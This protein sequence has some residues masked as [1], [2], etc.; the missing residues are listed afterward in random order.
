[1]TVA[2]VELWT[3]VRRLRTAFAGGA[4]MLAAGRAQAADRLPD[5]AELDRLTARL[6]AAV[7]AAPPLADPADALE[8]LAGDV[9]AGRYDRAAATRALTAIQQAT[10]PAL[11]G[12]LRPDGGLTAGQAASAAAEL[13]PGGRPVLTAH[14]LARAST[15][16]A[17][18]SPAEA[19]RLHIL[20]DSSSPTLAAYLL[21]ALAAGH[22][23]PRVDQLAADV[24][25]YAADSDWLHR[26][27]G[28]LDG[29]IGPAT[30]VDDAGNDFQLRQLAPVTCGPTALIV[31]RALVDPV[32]ALA[33]TTGGNPGDPAL[34]SA[35]MVEQRF[36]AEQNAV[37]HAATRGAVGPLPWPKRFG[38]P[39]WSAARH[40]NHLSWVTGVEYAWQPVDSADPDHL[41]E[42]LVSITLGLALGVPVPL[43]VGKQV[44]RHVVLALGHRER[45][46][47][48]YEPSRGAVVAIAEEDVVQNR[49]HAAGW[50]RLEGVLTP[51]PVN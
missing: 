3:V 40:L 1:V 39:P 31:L 10:G 17:A 50:P 44:D 5:P 2:P 23:L 37:H 32:Y 21:A 16:S 12:S 9:R 13:T 14:R 4:A 25:P 34:T 36:R 30:Y 45:R 15:A 28:L 6:R 42:Q 51:R 43:Y 18:L 8:R 48:V 22:R 33:L 29:A 49:L 19:E 38:T 41:R 47:E 35:R 11:L 27:L 26:H 24:A 20:L 46:I 7:P